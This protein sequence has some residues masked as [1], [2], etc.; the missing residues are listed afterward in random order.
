MKRIVTLL[1]V[2]VSS[3]SM[4]AQ[5]TYYNQAVNSCA[6]KSSEELISCIKN[7]YL[8]DYDFKTD[9][10]KLVSTKEIKKP[11]VLITAA[12][13]SAPCFGQVPALNRMV[14]KYHEQVEFIMIFWDSKDKIK[15]F[16]DKLDSRI[17]LIPAGADDKVEKGN[18]DISGFVHKLDYPTAYLIDKNKKF[19]DV[20]RGAATPSKTMNWDQVTDTN[21]KE[22]ET[23]ISQVIN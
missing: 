16:Q 8:L 5:R 11:I 18:L 20:K 1:L 10:D 14:K 7:S 21:T 9:Q 12:T 22:L 2:I 6:G 19:L 15:R 23:F 13:W 17:T 4:L 3:S